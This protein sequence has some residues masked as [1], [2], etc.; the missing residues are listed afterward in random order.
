MPLSKSIFKAYDI[1]G[2]VKDELTPEI[3]ELIGQAIGSE[4]I[5]K[6]ERGVVVGRDGRLSGIELMQALKSGLKKSGCHVVDI[7]MVPTPL[8]YYATYTKAATS[9]V[10][11]TGSHNP[12]EYNGFKIMIAG[13]TL[14]G[15]R[16]E[17]LYQRIQ[18]NDFCSGHGTSTRV[19]IEDDY[20][21]RIASD[22]KL[23]KPLHIVV[24]AG[25]GVAGNI[26]P[27]LFEQLGAKV[28]KLFCLVDGNFPNHHPDPSKLHN[29][30]D[31]I[32]EVKNTGADMGFAFD[33]DGDRLGLIDNKGGVIWAD[34]QMILYAR[35]ILKRNAGAK[36]VF[37]VKCSSQLP[38]DIIEHGG[39]AIMSR[40]GHSFIKAKLKATGAALGGEMS[41]HIFF[42]E[43]WYGFDDALYTGARLLEILSKTDKTCAQVFA[44]LP[45]SINT[46][47]INIHF[48]EQGQQF[49]AMDKLAKNIDFPQ[50]KITTIDGVRVDYDNGWG[51]VRP[52]NT[53]PCLVLRFEANDEKTLKEIQQK[54]RI[55]L[56]GNNIST[57]DF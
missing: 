4:S 39:E 26:A 24:D 12:P 25:N 17:A 57:Q 49:N 18:N 51:L 44:D 16:I 11:I 48:D 40:T 28:T 54:F 43:R 53:M 41:G 8:V 14:S 50:A 3:V 35:D 55:W 15:E 56:E 20:I 5:A 13:E 45:D 2:I 7:G 10:M 42:K 47:E 37:D 19:D 27:K 52:S 31:I 36:I 1:R 32:K 21:E 46:P 6:G 30:E 22:I 38:K 34:R 9:G 29:L 23:E 33:G